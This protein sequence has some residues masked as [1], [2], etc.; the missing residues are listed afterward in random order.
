VYLPLTCAGISSDV[1]VKRFHAQRLW[2]IIF[3][4][5]LFLFAQIA[6]L[7]ISN[8]LHLWIVATLTGLGYGF[9]IGVTP[10]LTSD[11]FGIRGLSTNWGA[12]MIAAVISGNALNLFYGRVFDDHSTRDDDGRM[13]CSS[14]LECYRNAY[15]I[16]TAAV[17]IGFGIAVVGM[18]RVRGRGKG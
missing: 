7:N 1:L 15:W 3:S 13:W 6:A 2:L 12:M 8:P 11:A 9:L 16:S 5:S 4:S 14:G 18:L 10:T 17:L